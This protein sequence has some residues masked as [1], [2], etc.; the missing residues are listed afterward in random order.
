MRI[1]LT[2]MGLPH[3]QQKYSKKRRIS[4]QNCGS[5]IPDPTQ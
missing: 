1:I 5:A 2:D 3:E 4:A